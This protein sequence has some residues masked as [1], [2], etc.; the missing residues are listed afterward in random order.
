MTAMLKALQTKPP[1]SLIS[2]LQDETSQNSGEPSG[3]DTSQMSH[4]GSKINSANTSPIKENTPTEKQV[5]R[6]IPAPLNPDYRSD[7]DFADGEEE[8]YLIFKDEQDRKEAQ[9]KAQGKTFTRDKWKGSTPVDIPLPDTSDE[10]ELAPRQHSRL[11]RLIITA[12][13]ETEHPPNKEYFKTNQSDRQ[14]KRSNATGSI[15]S[16]EDG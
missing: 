14:K 8:E 2:Q 6:D 13:D 10:E 7:E 5:K 3:S 11:K 16:G 4:D 15:D 9:A 12:S 1:Q